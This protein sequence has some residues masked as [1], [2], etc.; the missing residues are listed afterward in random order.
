MKL[1][2]L[3]SQSLC[4]HSKYFVASDDLEAKSI[5]RNFVYQCTDV[6][7][8]IGIDRHDLYLF[9][10]YS[11]ADYLNSYGKKIDPSNVTR[12]V[13]ALE[14]IPDVKEYISSLKN[15]PGTVGENLKFADD[16]ERRD[17]DSQG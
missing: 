11:V 6:G 10:H 9:E 8:M 3:F 15:K 2:S 12:Q 7:L 16:V 13:C 17:N 4:Q 1:Y 5:I 14:D